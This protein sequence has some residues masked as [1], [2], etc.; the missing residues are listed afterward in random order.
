VSVVKFS[1]KA[2][3]EMGEVLHC[4]VL[5]LLWERLDD[6]FSLQNFLQAT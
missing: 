2:C 5:A 3:Q 1:V 4:S 6:V